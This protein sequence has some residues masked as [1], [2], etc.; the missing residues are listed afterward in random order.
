V[1][2]YP[3]LSGA[4]SPHWRPDVWGAFLGLTLACSSGDIVR[5]VLE[6][7]AFQVRANLEVMEELGIVI[8]ELILFGGGAQSALWSQIICD[9]TCKPV[10]I[11]A[12]VD[13]A[14]WGA[15][16]LAGAGAGLFD[17]SVLNRSGAQAQGPR[18]SPRPDVAERYEEIYHLYRAH[19]EKLL[20]T[21]A[22]PAEGG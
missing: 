11:T 16:L 22:L 18:C 4:G 19:E 12:M 7:V 13:V 2:F 14:N 10:T 1:F 21:A 20:V 6:G 15:C 8:D 9:V 17:G 5:S 3:H